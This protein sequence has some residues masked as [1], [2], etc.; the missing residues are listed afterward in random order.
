MF[1]LQAL[2]GIVRSGQGTNGPLAGIIHGRPNVGHGVCKFHYILAPVKDHT[3]PAFEN[4]DNGFS[5][6]I[7]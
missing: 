2:T 1:I 7:V 3:M 6:G 5:S 4:S